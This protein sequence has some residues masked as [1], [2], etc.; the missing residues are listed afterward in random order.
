MNKT[1]RSNRLHIALL[2]RRNAGKSSFMNCFLGQDY[3]I[4]SHVPGTTTDPVEK[5]YELQPLGPVVLIDTAGIDD[6][7]EL[8]EKRTQKTMKILRRADVAVLLV[9][10]GEFGE[11]EEKIVTLCKTRQVPFLVALSKSDLLEREGG[12][13]ET[14][15]ASL[16]R[17]LGAPVVAT[18]AIS[19]SGFEDVKAA[20]AELAQQRG[21]GPPII[22]DLV[23]PPKPVVLVIPIDKEAPKGRLILP[24]VQTI[25]ELLDRG[26]PT[27]VCR[28]TELK[29]VLQN[30]GSLEPQLVVTDSQA[31]AYVSKV[32]PEGIP[33]TSF[34]ILF[35]RHK[36]NLEVYYQGL[37]ALSELKDGDR[38]LIAELCS[39][40]PIGEDIGRVKIPRWIREKSG[41]DLTFD[42]A[43]GRD[44]PEDLTPYA[45]IIQ[46]G[47]CMVNRKTII[48]RINEAVT[49]GVPISNYGLIISSLNGIVEATVAPLKSSPGV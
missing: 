13:V 10:R 3:T 41:L 46:C 45:L 23:T 6:V 42:V 15:V 32:V 34:S 38:I 19:G 9:E 49:Q 7:G 4:V 26:I 28:E 20:L 18:C 1:P 25:R 21:E 17:Q 47:G 24:Q 5:S 39:H 35:S 8:G 11:W 44:F 48:D 2:G 22:A 37:S 30:P 43:A 33:L 36:G 16:R 12:D 29:Q 14:R 27:I 40:R 31:F